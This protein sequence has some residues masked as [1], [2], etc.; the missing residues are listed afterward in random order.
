MIA[1]HICAG[2]ADKFLEMARAFHIEDGH[3]LNAAGER[4]IR[5]VAAGVELAPAFFLMEDGEVVGFFVLSLGYSPE[6][7]GTDGFIDDIYLIP[8]VRGRGLGKAA[9]ALALEESRNCG[10]RV[11]L[12]EVEA[13]NDRAYRL[14]SSMGF[15]DTKRRLLRLILAED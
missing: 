2:D 6:H 13:E 5:D 10:I 11:L 15:T 9:M 7:G 1:R 12:L 8:E 3:K 4:S 14:Y